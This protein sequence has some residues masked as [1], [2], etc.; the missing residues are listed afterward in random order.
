M[1]EQHPSQIMYATSANG[2]LKNRI[3]ALVRSHWWNDP[4][5][6]PA[7]PVPLGDLAWAVAANPTILAAVTAAIVDGNIG[8][9]VDQIA[10]GDLEFVVLQALARLTGG[11]P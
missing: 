9:A 8:A 2:G 10:E 1:T 7:A 5:V 3:E 6:D 4:A 11:T